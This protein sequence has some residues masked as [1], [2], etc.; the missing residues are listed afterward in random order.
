MGG[1]CTGLT[2]LGSTIICWSGT[3]TNGWSVEATAEGNDAARSTSAATM[4]PCGPDPARPEEA[5]PAAM[6]S[7]D[8]P[9]SFASF[10]AN[11]E[12]KS[13]PADAVVVELEEIGVLLC[14]CGEAEEELSGVGARWEL[15]EDVAGREEGSAAGDGTGAALT[16][17]SAVDIVW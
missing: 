13:L 2:V 1:L 7:I 14:C 10:R 15:S 5:R 4:R 9:D 11:G 8:V 17:A 16:L 3:G 6:R 12:E